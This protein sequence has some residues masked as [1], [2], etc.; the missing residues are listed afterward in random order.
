[1]EEVQ[2]MPMFWQIFLALV[3][4]FGGYELLKYLINLKSNRKKEKAEAG[5]SQS[6]S[7]MA[8]LEVMERRLEIM[9]KQLIEQEEKLAEN[10]RKIMEQSDQIRDLTAQLDEAKNN[11]ESLRKK[12]T[13]AEETIARLTAERKAAKIIKPKPQLKEEEI[14]EVRDGEL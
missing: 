1:M 14:K 6:E 12:L 7:N 10:A 5:K 8:E 4:A 13:S 11:A 2:V 9:G 3:S